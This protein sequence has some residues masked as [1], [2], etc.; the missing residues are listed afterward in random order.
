ML[1]NLIQNL[2]NYKSIGIF[3]FG[4]EGKSF[5]NFAKRYIPDTK[6]VI[7]DSNDD[8]YL[9]ELSKVDL[10][11]KSPGISLH[12][13]N[14]DVNG[15]NFTS[16]TE[17]FL[18][19]FS[20]QVVGIT[21]TKGK[22]TLATLLYDVLKNSN[23]EVVLCGNIGLPA[24]DIVDKIKKDT[25]VVMEL[26]SH[27]L[28]HMKYSPKYAVLTNLFEDHLDY[29]KDI[30]EYHNAKL[31]IFRYQQEDDVAI[32]DLE[33]GDKRI[34]KEIF[35]TDKIYNIHDVH[36]KHNIDFKLEQGFIH[37]ST[38]KILEQLIQEFDVNDEI[39]LKTLKRFK[40]L[41]HRL[42]YVGRVMDIDFINDSIST[43]P[44]A[45]IEAINILKSVDTLI[46]GGFDRGIDYEVLVSFL[47]SSNV[48][49]IILYS[50]TGEILKKLFN[51]QENISIFYCKNLDQSVVKAFEVTKKGAICLFSPAASSFDSYKNF[52]ERGIAFKNAVLNYK[53]DSNAKS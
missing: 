2:S 45:T 42:E 31:N 38:L 39:Y 52:E 29:Y 12:N 44:Q 25:T 33:D 9:D 26:S 32:F 16:M 41:P 35:K 14:I 24:F 3:G 21:G 4:K 8:N 36:I 51:K 17:L 48:G 22:S 13:L 53:E 1:K 7:I 43:I 10:V 23:Q 46:L 20:K 50:Q 27:Q 5:Y 37:N 15:Y 30:D 19:Y 11:V 34:N 6:L 47:V 49:N 28:M 40:T 18:K